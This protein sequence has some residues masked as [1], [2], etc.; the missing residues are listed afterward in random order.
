MVTQDSSDAAIAVREAIPSSDMVRVRFSEIDGLRALAIL[1]A[2]AYEVIRLAGASGAGPPL[3]VRLFADAS[4]GISLFFLL[5]GFVLA[6]P[7]LVTLREDGRTYLDVG[8]Y[9]V[10][11]LLRIYPAYLVVLVL[12][13]V[14]PPLALQ[15]GLPALAG[16]QPPPAGET[17]VRNLFFLGNGLGN[18]AFRALALEAR[19][20]VLFPAA[21]L[22]WARSRRFFCGAVGLAALLDLF[23]PG[24]HAAGVGALVPFMLGI[25]AADVRASHH[26]LERFG[27]VVAAVAAAAALLVES[28]LAGL[29]GPSGAPQAL[30]IDPLWSIALFGLLAGAGTWPIVE[31]MLA[32]RPLRFLGAAS[33][34][35]ALVA[36]PVSAFVVRQVGAH[37]GPGPTAAN[38]AAVSILAGIVVWQLSDRWFAEGTIRRD[39]AAFV[40]PWVDA[41]LRFARI[42]RV[43]LGPP[44]VA[45]IEEPSDEAVDTQFYAPPPRSENGELAIVS[46]RS[47]SPEE[48][49]A[50]ILET[51]RR[52]ADRS[53]AIFGDAMPEPEQGPPE[54]PP[55]PPPPAFEK[56]G[57]YRKTPAKAAASVPVAPAPATAAPAPA[58]PAALAPAPAAPAQSAP[59]PTA[60]SLSP[61]ASAARV[62]A[63]PREA[64]AAQAPA[65]AGISLSF[66]PPAY[67]HYTLESA[68]APRPAPVPQPV[69]ARPVAAPVPV[70]V[71]QPVVAA[72]PIPAQPVAPPR[73]VPQL[74]PR[75]TVPGAPP[76]AHAPRTLGPAAPAPNSRGPIKMRIGAAAAPPAAAPVNTPLRPVDG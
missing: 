57:F 2:V 58:A 37:I 1:T 56:P 73:F 68:A 9:L 30:R 31:R 67:Q 70:P 65:H 16:G 15:Y 28:A 40:G 10:K 32:L 64:V 51:K 59:A 19:W 26:R 46:T 18:D 52:L 49:A 76:P 21:L 74:A 41:V 42:D 50:D 55:P 12:T 62:A 39:A 71:P 72:R 61:A 63:P 54:P 6:Y 23:V 22:L 8:R 43:T 34:G 35:I 24:A 60:P 66:E 17:F 45:E 75:A 25:I 13:F 47:G 44:L 3:L 11:R 29:P 4:Q 53:A 14:V 48:L 38:A 7:A 36:V 5:S 69:A 27:F 33:Y 20:L